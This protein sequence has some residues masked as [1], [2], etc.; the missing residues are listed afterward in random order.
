V[1]LVTKIL[2]NEDE[3]CLAFSQE[4]TIIAKSTFFRREK[5]REREAQ[6]FPHG[7]NFG[8]RTI[9]VSLL[10]NPLVM[11]SWSKLTI[12]TKR[13]NNTFDMRTKWF[14]QLSFLMS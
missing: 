10:M 9:I 6:I 14:E 5:E 1:A 3:S 2:E 11:G 8:I 4:K 13:C 12:N 7:S